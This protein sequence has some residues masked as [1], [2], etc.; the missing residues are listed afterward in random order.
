MAA[1]TADVIPTFPPP[2]PYYLLYKNTED[3]TP[4]DIIPPP[5]PPPPEEYRV[6]GV[7]RQKG[8]E[9]K[10]EE[11]SLPPHI[12]SLPQSDHLN[13]KTEL[14][15]QCSSLLF[16]FYQLLDVLVNDQENFQAKTEDIEILL[17]NITHLLNT[18]RPHQTRQTI[19]QIFAEQL[20]GKAVCI[21]EAQRLQERVREV[22]P[23]LSEN[24]RKIFQ[25]NS[26]GYC[27]D[28]FCRNKATPMEVETEKKEGVLNGSL[29]DPKDQF[30]SFLESLQQIV[31]IEV[32][33]E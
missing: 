27:R 26:E 20:G 7:I 33:E 21:E 4:E 10:L 5:P 8:D 19:I 1:E 29:K 6:F 16:G 9:E 3:Q 13:Q 23:S 2:P 14:K 15:K 12:L 11:P 30:G 24:L 22:L 18:F 32:R 25:Q 28:Y 31:D 17:M